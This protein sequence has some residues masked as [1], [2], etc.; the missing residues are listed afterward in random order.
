MLESRLDYRRLG[1]N[2]SLLQKIWEGLGRRSRSTGRERDLGTRLEG[3]WR[4]GSVLKR[5]RI[6]LAGYM[7]GIKQAPQG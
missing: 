7:H 1:L 6:L 2:M 4:R 5:S 3:R